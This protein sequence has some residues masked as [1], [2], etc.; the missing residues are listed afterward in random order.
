MELDKLNCLKGVALSVLELIPQ[1]KE[2]VG[3]L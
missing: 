1:R 3:I 2:A